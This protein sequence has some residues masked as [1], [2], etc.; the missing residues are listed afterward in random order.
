MTDE[1]LQERRDRQ[2]REAR[3][4]SADHL[5]HELRNIENKIDPL[6]SFARGVQVGG[7]TVGALNTMM[8]GMFGV[9]EWPHSVRMI[10]G[11][12]FLLLAAHFLLRQ[13]GFM[14]AQRVNRSVSP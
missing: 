5:D 4:D 3:Q 8:P 1:T 6:P 7:L 14:M 10:V 9:A 12:V 13:R 2:I 11:L